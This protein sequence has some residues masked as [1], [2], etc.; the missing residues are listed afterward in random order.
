MDVDAMT[1]KKRNEN[2]PLH[3]VC[4]KYLKWKETTYIM[5]SIVVAVRV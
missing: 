3:Q 4:K 5:W 1:K 2:A